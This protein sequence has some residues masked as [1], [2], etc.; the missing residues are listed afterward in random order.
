MRVAAE[1]RSDGAVFSD[2]VAQRGEL[3][4]PAVNI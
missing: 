4:A 2:D 1:Q 3:L